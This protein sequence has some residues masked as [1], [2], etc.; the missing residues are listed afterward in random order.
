MPPSSREFP[1]F[2]H[3]LFPASA[4]AQCNAVLS[5]GYTGAYF[6]STCV[7]SQIDNLRKLPPA[8][9]AA[10]VD[11]YCER[12]AANKMPLIRQVP[13]AAPA[14]QPK[15]SDKTQTGS[16]F[17]PPPPPPPHPPPP[18]APPPPPSSSQFSHAVRPLYTD[19]RLPR[20]MAFKGPKPEIGFHV[21]R[22]AP[23]SPRRI[24]RAASAAAS[25]ARLLPKR[26]RPS[27]T[28]WR[29]PNVKRRK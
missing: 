20:D 22:G 28:R 16:A 3:A 26:S 5:L 2:S 12:A 21:F 29:T 24:Y 1:P 15:P 17:T 19:R 9:V 8:T 27:L 7:A 6:S 11:A 13:F 10:I 25:Q 18:T 4:W 23:P 14:T